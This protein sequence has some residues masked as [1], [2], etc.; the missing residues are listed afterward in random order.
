[1][2]LIDLWD[3]DVDGYCHSTIRKFYNRYKNEDCV[4]A[5]YKSPMGF[6]ALFKTARTIKGIAF[7]TPD[8][9][10]CYYY[11]H[12]VQM[13][14][15]Q[16]INIMKDEAVVCMPDEYSKIKKQIILNNIMKDD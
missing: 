7:I 6:V 9:D 10:S 16:A 2:K 1:M 3:K 11:I 5:Y 14:L 8:I 15:Q 13:S 12:A 4:I